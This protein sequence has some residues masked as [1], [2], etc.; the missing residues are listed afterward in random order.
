MDCSTSSS[1]CA[2]S[3]RSRTRAA[4]S[5]ASGHTHWRTIC[6]TGA[7]NEE[8]PHPLFDTS[9]YLE[10]N[11]DVATAG[12]NPLVHF[13]ASGGLEG[14]DPH[15]LF[16]AGFYLS[17]NPD[18]AD[19]R[20]NPLV[21]FL[22]RGAHE[23]RDP[24]P[25][26]DTSFYLGADPTLRKSGEN[27]LVHYLRV[28]ASEG[29]STGVS[30][31]TRHYLRTN[32]DVARCGV[33]PLTHYVLAGRG[34]GR[35]PLAAPTLPRAG[36]IRSSNAA[37]RE[38]SVRAHE[39]EA[40]R[41]GGLVLDPPSIIR[42]PDDNLHRHARG[43]T[44]RA[45]PSPLVSIVIPAV[46]G[47]RM[48][49]E[50]LLSV[51][52]WSDEVAIEIIVV[53][54]GSTDGS[55]ALLASIPH[56]VHLR[57]EAKMGFGL[58]CN[59]GAAAARG[60]YVLFLNNDAQAQQGWLSALLR[61][62]SEKDRVVAA[63]PKLLFPDGRLQEA[64]SA[65][66][67]DCTSTLIGVF[68]DPALPRFNRVTE[69]DYVSG[70]CLMV[71]AG[72]FRD[73][74]GFDSGFAPAYCEDIDLCLRLRREGGRILYQPSAVVVHHLSVT[75][76]EVGETFKMTAVV[77]NQQELSLRHQDEID[78]LGRARI[79][80]FYLPQFHP[81]PEN[82]V[83]W[84]KG[85]TE[86]RNVTRAVPNFEG[87]YQPRLCGDL[88]YYD[89]RLEHTYAE[90]VK[91]ARRYGVDG[92]CFYYYWFDGKRLLER[93]LERLLEPGA[94]DFPFCLCWANENWTRRWDGLEHE[95]LIAQ[96]HRD[97]DET[98]VL[99]DLQRY[100]RHP[101]YIRIDGRPLLLVYRA[102]LFPHIRKTLESWRLQCRH[103][104]IGEIFLGMVESF[105]LSRVAAT[106]HD[107]GFDAA[108][109]FPPHN[110]GLYPVEPDGL[111]NSNFAGRVFDY[112][113]TALHYMTRPQPGYRRF[114]TVMPDWDNTA[115]R[116]NDGVIFTGST[117]G[118][119]QAW[120]EWVLRQ[121]HHQNFGDERVVFINAWN[122]W[123][124]GAYIEPDLGWGHAY[125]E[126]TR[127]ATE[128]VSLSLYSRG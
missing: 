39:L 49:L 59:T 44:L 22:S 108:V 63:G 35:T 18:V 99:D 8:D 58:A 79:I 78:D 46:N 4:I 126:A 116:Q 85:F 33:N 60:R 125:L 41:I 65:I 122:E 28:G 27:P 114:R 113:R 84:G 61:S 2:S 100:L 42:L 21:H 55:S 112:N 96:S 53:D 80:A 17:Q 91:L 19:A 56:L 119:Y 102:S 3:R 25:W 118:G 11:P 13:L 82:D 10:R 95:I 32:P 101:S 106:P 72:R 6:F 48:T 50:C 87:H 66:N 74:G 51:V 104:G 90:Q 105:E 73:L 54:N 16:H 34:E 57:H 45:E 71:D 31:D 94:P 36:D 103:R 30:F 98:A 24:N 64:G 52:R 40:A 23:G 67:S 14:R 123:A 75:S 20:V 70:A 69:V 81:I 62:F 92:F 83:W 88:G 5:P 43:V 115:R 1:T 26:F 97:T 68:D 86:W 117:P 77:R 7:Y 89:L 76:N 37:Y 121:T 128:N 111:L 107:L 15:P 110:G 109:E 29:R 47:A 124:E 9:F 38:V 127:D 120:L 12:I 93:P